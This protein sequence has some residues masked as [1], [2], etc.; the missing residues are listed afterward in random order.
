MFI[1][2]LQYILRFDDKS[3]HA[4]SLTLNRKFMNYD[5]Y[6]Q[7]AAMEVIHYACKYYDKP[8]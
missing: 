4:F 2:T 5:E 7:E 3:F 6:L 1:S 8:D